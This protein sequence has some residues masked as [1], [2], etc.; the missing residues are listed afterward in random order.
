MAH[1]TDAEM[2]ATEHGKISKQALTQ[3]MEMGATTM[4]EVLKADG[5]IPEDINK[6]KAASE[7]I[8]RRNDPMS[9]PISIG[10]MRED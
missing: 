3:Y 10:G 9:S 7:A 2:V 1:K 4:I 6:K 8:R 5:L